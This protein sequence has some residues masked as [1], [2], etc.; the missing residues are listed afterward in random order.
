VATEFTPIDFSVNR[1]GGGTMKRFAV[2]A[3]VIG[4]AGLGLAGAASAQ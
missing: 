2:A 1:Q 4:V 3:I